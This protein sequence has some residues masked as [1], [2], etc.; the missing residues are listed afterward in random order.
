MSRR[1]HMH[2][3]AAVLVTASAT[4]VAGAAFAQSDENSASNAVQPGSTAQK[5]LEQNQNAANEINE[6]MA[7]A[8]NLLM[9]PHVKLIPGQ[10]SV[11]SVKSPVA[12]DSTAATRGMKY[13]EGF[14]CV[15][16]HA[17]N[18]GGGM[19]IS[20]SNSNSK[21]GSDAASIYLVISHGAPLGMPAWGSVLPDN[22]IW[23]IVAYVQSISKPATQW[24]ETVSAAD[25]LP[26]IEQ[27]PAEFQQSA[28]PWQH[29]QP[30]SMGQKPTNH[31]Q[32]WAGTPTTTGQGS[33]ASGSQ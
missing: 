5:T 4:L 20:L 28:T 30:F 12:N 6:V 2:F 16:C 17:S 29:T 8:G 11:P 18:G 24:G 21:F 3:V 33:P 32:T 10:V 1:F 26:A 15:G 22:V 25:K 19:G 14:N 27:V 23:D 7:S 9:V 31:Q 13:F